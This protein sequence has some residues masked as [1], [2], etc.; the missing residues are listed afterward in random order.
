M[1]NKQIETII[2]NENLEDLDIKTINDF[3]YNRKN[4]EKYVSKNDNP[5]SNILMVLIH[6]KLS[7][8]IAKYVWKNI[9]KHLNILEK[10]LKREVGVIVATVDYMQN[11]RKTK[12]NLKII[13]ED[14]FESI[15]EIA[16]K[17]ELTKLYN[18]EVLDIFLEK[19]NEKA[20]RE[21]ESFSFMMFDIDDFKEVN[22]NYGHQKGDEVIANIAKIISTNIRK[23]DIAFRYGGEE[24]CVIFPDANKD[25]AFK[26]A[27]KIREK[28]QD[29][30]KDDLKTTVSIGVSDNSE[31]SNVDE[32]IK[33]ADE[34]LYEAKETGKNKTIV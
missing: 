21:K 10:K 31:L 2:E 3:A 27:E 17:D 6:S 13:S 22:D 1:K 30:Y 9:I 28:I 29:T 7:E 25:E 15:S 23:M 14:N 26:I 34:N 12:S 11:I 8:N 18:R 19:T 4:L 5:Y 24:L 33:K 32:I 16:T 20:F